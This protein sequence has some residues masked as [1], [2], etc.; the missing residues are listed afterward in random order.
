MS[1][2]P[3]NLLQR[4]AA[5]IRPPAVKGAPPTAMGY[6]LPITGG[7]IPESWPWN[8]WQQGRD[9]VSAGVSP[10]V[11]ACVS[12]YAET[13]ASLPARHVS[14]VPGQG[15][16]VVTTSPLS[17]ILRSPNEY[18][19]GVDFLDCLV[20]D[21]YATGNSMCAA[22]R[23]DRHQIAELHP[24]PARETPLHVAY[25]DDGGTAV[26]YQ[27]PTSAHLPRTL[28]G[29]ILPA[30]DVLHLRLHTS[31]RS[32][33]V[34]QSPVAHLAASIE[35]TNSIMQNGATFFSNMSRPSGVITT[36]ERLTKE[37]MAVLRETWQS[38]SAALN[39]GRV[40]I[41]GSGL[42]WQSLSINS[43]DA[44]LIASYE[45]G[46]K[47]IARAFRVPLPLIGDQSGA[48]QYGTTEAL[49]SL[50]LAMGL[51]HTLELIETGI[52]RFFNLPPTQRLDLDES[53]L[54]RADQAA[55]AE[56]L[57]KLVINGIL[58]PNEARLR[59]GLPDTPFGDEPR[60][61]SQMVPLSAAGA[62]AEP[63]AV[64][65]LPAAPV[66]EVRALPPP[67][68]RIAAR[69]RLVAGKETP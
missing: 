9:P 59:E 6:P 60:A 61:Q 57:A 25:D 48:S 27:L 56:V 58:S 55:R 47:E 30:R 29:A 45:L 8:W 63:D 46:A 5:A 18:Q 38:Q 40:P 34:G 19:S 67:D 11:A 51:G 42:K 69:L 23:D 62:V 50:W 12:T 2:A 65:S 24:L 44:Q 41:L 39:S 10:I 14:E 36:D 68:D 53:A 33:L 7:F 3:T 31:A 66:S 16:Q 21:L 32:P 20:R 37:Q 26:F 22:I 54:L 28:A 49:A 43:V 52:S 35:M 64:V 17:R 13:V 15:V 4:L 1:R